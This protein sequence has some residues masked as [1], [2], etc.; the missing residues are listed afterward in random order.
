MIG[1]VR[2]ETDGSIAWHGDTGV[3]LGPVMFDVNGVHFTIDAARGDEVVDLAA[4]DA[5]SLRGVTQWFADPEVVAAI[6]GAADGEVLPGP[7]AGPE[8]TRTATV[9]A[10][11]AI[12]LGDLESAVLFVDRGYAA[13]TIGDER[14]S[15]RGYGFGGGALER[16]VAEIESRDYVGPLNARLAEVIA[17]APPVALGE[18]ERIALLATLDARIGRD[19]VAWDGFLAEVAAGESAPALHLGGASVVSDQVADLQLLPPRLLVFRGPDEADIAVTRGADQLHLS[20]AL[21]ADVHLDSAETNGIFA[22][23]ADSG[24]GTLLAYAPMRVEGGQ[25][26]ATIALDGLDPDA[27]RCGLVGS[28]ADLSTVRLD[29]LGAQLGRIDRYCRYAWSE[30]RR[31]GALLGSVGV[32][33]A[34]DDLVRAEAAAEEA[35]E[36]AEDA[37][38]TAS[39]LARKLV[40]SFHDREFVQDLKDYAEAVGRLARRIGDPPA[41]E[42]PSGPTLAELYSATLG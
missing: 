14:Q 15:L 7:F 24:T 23:A 13:T 19:D 35:R 25:L 41:A 11:D 40:R 32:G 34:T 42:G 31:A 8:L 18:A 17:V 16:L 37:I 5:A 12:Y 30:H 29:P 1:T 39:S 36:I 21:R 6:A 38:D 4:A 26:V 27:L 3:A 22:V 28:A 9:A 33:V 2:I 20:A 10:V